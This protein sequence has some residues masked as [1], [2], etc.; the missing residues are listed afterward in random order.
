MNK[1][2]D[3]LIESISNEI[4]VF[5]IREC[6]KNKNNL[7]EVFVV[8]REG[9]KNLL[10]KTDIKFLELETSKEE[11]AK[12][13]N[14]GFQCEVFSLLR[15]KLEKKQKKAKKETKAV[16]REE[17]IIEEKTKEEKRTDKK[18]EKQEKREAKEKAREEKKLNKAQKKQKL[19]K[20][21]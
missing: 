1:N 8:G 2:I 9:T 20:N 18:S 16:K 5:G 7:K 6:L 13:L 10:R 3:K 17:T 11:T 12:K 14:L 19:Q 4:V 15:E 21:G